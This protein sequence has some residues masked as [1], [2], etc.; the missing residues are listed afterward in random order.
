MKQQLVE[1]TWDG[2][3]IA[4]LKNK[5]NV[6]LEEYDNLKNELAMFTSDFSERIYQDVN[7]YKEIMADNTLVDGEYID[8]LNQVNALNLILEGYN[9]LNF[10]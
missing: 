8:L 5:M 2:Q 9:H 3:P 4:D 1:L 6:L 10:Q 7:Y